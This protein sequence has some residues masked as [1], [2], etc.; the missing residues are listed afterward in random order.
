MRLRELRQQLALLAP[1]A[2]QR[3]GE[4]H[5]VDGR[6]L[7]LVNRSR[8][9]SAASESGRSRPSAA[10]RASLRR[11]ARTAPP[12]SPP[13]AG[14][15]GAR[16]EGR[17]DPAAW[18]AAAGAGELIAPPATTTCLALTSVAARPR[19]AVEPPAVQRSA[20]TRSPCSSESTRVCT[21]SVAPRSSAA[22]IVVTSIDCLALVGQPM[23]Q[24]PRFQ[25]PFTLRLIIGAVM[26]SEVAP[27]RSSSLLSFGAISQ[28]PT[29][30]RRS[31]CHRTRARAPRS[32][33]RRGRT[34]IANA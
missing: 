13:G 33:S 32:R 6:C 21:N 14:R 26:P 29:L 8:R 28:G 12:R 7:Q 4:D 1:E 24:E 20:S 10:H 3:R 2:R 9:R 16:G 22:G 18:S 30:R 17:A 31:A 34:A 27:L 25:Q 19:R 11:H 23:P 15:C 5:R